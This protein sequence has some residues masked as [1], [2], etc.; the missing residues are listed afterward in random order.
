M[1][2]PRPPRGH[3]SCQSS[4]PQCRPALCGHEGPRLTCLPRYKP[5]GPSHVP[6]RPWQEPESPRPREERRVWS[7]VLG[8][9]ACPTQIRTH[10]TPS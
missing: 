10:P 1:G 9:P 3:A 8:E 4:P 2:S 6:V 5:S 7:R